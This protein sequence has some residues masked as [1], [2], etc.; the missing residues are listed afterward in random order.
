MTKNNNIRE[1]EKIAR[2]TEKTSESIRKKHRALKT[3]K[4]EDDIAVRTRFKPIIE[5]LQKI[6][7]SSS[8]YAIKDESELP[9]D[10]DVKTLSVQKH[11]EDAKLSKR[12]RSNTSLDCR[13]KRLDVSG[14]DVSPITSTPSVT[15]VHP[16]MPESLANEDVFETT[17]DS[18]AVSIQNQL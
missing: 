4:V 18:L 2:E 11:E 16:T 13:S 9:N 14:L 3:G 8:M 17:D 15:T 1:R 7:D 10:D 12:K 5:P 6:A